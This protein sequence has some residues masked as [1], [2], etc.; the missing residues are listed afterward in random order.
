MA[1]EVKKE[2]EEEK[3]KKKKKRRKK[4]DMERWWQ[5]GEEERTHT[6]TSPCTIENVFR[7]MR[8][9]GERESTLSLSFKKIEEK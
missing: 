8:E 3:E 2:E 4:I 9:G 6:R 5:Q 1:A 7:C